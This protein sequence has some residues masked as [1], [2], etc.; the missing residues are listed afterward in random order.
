MS[1]YRSRGDSTEGICFF[2]SDGTQ[3]INYPKQHS[4]NMTIRHQASNSWLK[5]MV[6]ILKNMRKKLVADG[7]LEAGVAPSY[8]LEGL[9][10][11]VPAS[12]FGQSYERSFANAINWI[13]LEADK[14]KLV[15]A[16]EQYYLLWDETPTSWEFANADKFLQAAINQWNEW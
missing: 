9:L 13:Q 5:P 1:V 14:S 7:I 2:T 3:I 10:Y 12:K 11:N 4:E 6:R 8:Y 15:C 16:N